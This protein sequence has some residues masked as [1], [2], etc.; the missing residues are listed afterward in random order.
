[1]REGCAFTIIFLEEEKRVG[2]WPTTSSLLSSS[3]L[4][5]CLFVCHVMRPMI[6]QEKGGGAEDPNTFTSLLHNTKLIVLYYLIIII[7]S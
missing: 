7:P 6:S 2:G 4:F 1:M 5:V 3:F